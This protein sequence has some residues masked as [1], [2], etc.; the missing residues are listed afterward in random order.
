[1]VLM[2]TDY[3]GSCIVVLMGTDYTGSCNSGVNWH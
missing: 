2:G 3:T 1:V